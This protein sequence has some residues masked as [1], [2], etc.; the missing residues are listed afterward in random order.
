M[1]EP[2]KKGDKIKVTY[3]GTL[4]DGSVFDS[5]EG[6]E[7]LAFEVDG[8][9]VVK[10]FDN[11]TVG[12][13]VGQEKEVTLQPAEAYG[14]VNPELMKKVGRDK[15]PQDVEP[16]Q[17]A[18]IG[19]STPDGQQFPALIVDV[20]DTEV[21]IDLNHPLAGKVLHFKIKVESVDA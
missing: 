19:I 9:Q 3:T 16:K 6:K 20:T 18:V 14:D 8:G 11:A 4:D 2:V 12:M 7:P 17:G 13:T 5:S 10:G 1:T 15:L 21:T